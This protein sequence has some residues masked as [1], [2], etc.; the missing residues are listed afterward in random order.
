MR[1]DDWQYFHD[2]EF[3]QLLEEYETA[4]EQGR[5]L[6]LDAD[7]LTDIAEY[8][9][10][11]HEE[12]KADQAI[13]LATELHPESVDPQIFLARQQM[14]HGNLDEA[15]RICD[16]ITDQ[17]DQE[18]AFLKAE[19]LIREDKAREASQ[20]LETTYDQVSEQR[21]LF[22]C[23]A[24]GV[25]LDY[26]LWD[27]A[28]EWAERLKREYPTYKKGQ[29]VMAD[30]LFSQGETQQAIDTLNQL[31][32]TDPYY[33]EAWNL[34]A[35]AQSAADQFSE[36]L[37]SIE[38]VLAIEDNNR[39]ALLTKAHCL[40]QLEEVEQAH[41]IYQQLLAADPHDDTVYY[42]D[43]LCLSHLERYDEAAAALDKANDAGRGMSS[44]QLNI[45]LHQAYVESKLHHPQKAIHA[46]KQ[47]QEINTE[48]EAFNYHLLLGQIYL[49]NDQATKAAKH[50][51]EALETSE[52][53][54]NTMLLIGMAYGETMHYAEG[55]H[56]LSTLLRL[57]GADE[58]KAAIPYLAY[59]YYHLNDTENYLRYLRLA[60]TVSRETTEYLFSPVFPGVA[61]EDY[62]HYAFQSVYGHFPDEAE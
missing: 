18:V 46:L 38:Y 50:F 57:Y 14:F 22:L 49:E 5:M 8:Y 55:A 15:H 13:Q 23:D 2:P 59:C 40:F 7:E 61:P 56:V 30:V 29:F 20:L 43:A 51:S 53:P 44:E 37:E 21:A 47:A 3:T 42:F 25:F 24:A 28:R 54:K 4:Q 16:S 27:I 9:M 41:Q 45:Y 48:G 1:E 52:D 19:L 36:A 17:T 6:Y 11:L 26:A 35:E 12:E 34:L 60:A 31:L 10:L 33:V 32:D 62:Y 58:G 39:Q